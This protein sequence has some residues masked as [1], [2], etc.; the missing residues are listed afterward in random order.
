MRWFWIDRYLEFESGRY[1]VAVKNV[2]L[3]EEHLHDHFP[4][5]PV[6]PNSLIVEGIAQSGGLLVA[7][8]NNFAKR[9]VLAKVSRASFHFL[10]LPGDTLIYR[11]KIEEIKGDGAMVSATCHVGD[12]L[13]AEVDMFF[14]HLSEGQGEGE[15]FHPGVLLAWLRTLRVF[16]VGR[17]ADGSPLRVPDRLAPYDPINGAMAGVT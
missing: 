9:V 2:S 7:E 1:A 14:A 4:G 8:Y 6:M 17:A 13:Q 3:A 10:A 12:R 16:E 5:A 11:T 15:L